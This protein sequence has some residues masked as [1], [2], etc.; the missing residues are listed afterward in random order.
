MRRNRWGRKSLKLKIDDFSGPDYTKF[1]CIA[2]KGLLVGTLTFK[3]S[4]TLRRTVD[5]VTLDDRVEP[6]MTSRLRRNGDD[7]TAD[8][9]DA[10][11][12]DDV[13]TDDVTADGVDHFLLALASK[14]T[15]FSL[16]VTVSLRR[17]AYC[18]YVGIHHLVHWNPNS[19]HS[20]QI[21]VYGINDIY[22][23]C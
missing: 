6:L 7:V 12:T 4:S 13:T 8:S 17:L 10:E 5:D 22:F 19:K 3:T 14:V 2:A 21:L 9:V 18:S 23:T 16:K 11:T 20:N 1:A 15:K